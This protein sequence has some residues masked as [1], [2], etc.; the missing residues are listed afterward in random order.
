[1]MITKHYPSIPARFKI[2]LRG[3]NLVENIGEKLTG[4]FKQGDKTN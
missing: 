4:A 3:S 1:M 2:W